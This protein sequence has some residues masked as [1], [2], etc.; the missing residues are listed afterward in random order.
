[1]YHAPQQ[2]R[3]RWFAQWS[4]GKKILISFLI[5]TLL[6]VWFLIYMERNLKEPLMN[7]ARIRVLQVATEAINKSITNQVANS[8]NLKNLLTTKEKDNGEISAF[9]L[10]NV[11]QLRIQ[12]ET[13]DT[14]QGV[15]EELG[16]LPEKIPLGQALGSAII[17]SFGPR[18]P[19]KFK[20]MGAAKVEFDSRMTETGI[21]NVQI[22]WFLRVQTEVSIIIPF[23][24]EPQLVQTEIPIAYVVTVGDVPTYYYDSDRAGDGN[25]P[26]APA[27]SIPSGS[28]TSEPTL[29]PMTSPSVAPL[30]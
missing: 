13:I 12:A 11:E 17:S 21:N 30:P 15:F 23:D 9:L 16:E 2:K 24:T 25:A 27:I 8:D 7:V 20:P 14:V 29:G 26:Q 22:E 5:V 1:M 28:L 19:V 3:R 6:G 10:D 4:V 18:V